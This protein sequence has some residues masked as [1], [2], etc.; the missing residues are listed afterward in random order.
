MLD[1]SA[2]DDHAIAVLGLGVSGL[3]A[4][5][6]L[7]RAG[8]R[9]LPWDDNENRRN[10][11]AARGLTPCNL[12][13]A[14]FGDI[15]M[16][17][18]SPGIP[19]GHPHTHPV[20]ARARDAKCEILCDIELLT[21]AAPDARYIGI[22]GTNGKST[23]TAL[24][25]HI[26]S[27][28]GVASA[29]GGNIGAPA[30]SLDALGT[31]GVYVLELSSYQLDLLPAAVFDVAVLLNITP[32]H[33]DRHGGMDGY[34]AAKRR[35]FDGQSATQSAIVG[36]DDTYAKS[37]FSEVQ[38]RDLAAMTPISTRGVC[39]GGIY[40][41][42]GWII[43]DRADN[44]EQIIEMR[45]LPALPGDHNAQNVATAYGAVTAILKS[46]TTEIRAGIIASIARFPGL[47]HR[48]E[49]LGTKGPVRFVNDSKATNAEAAAHALAAYENIYWIAGG[50]AK[51]GGIAALGPFFDRIRHAFLI[52][53]AAEDFEA[54]LKDR[55]ST[56]RSGDLAT[57]TQQ[58][59]D[60]A[61]GDDNA[62]VLLSPACASFDQFPS[63]EA[64]GDAFRTAV[65]A[66]P[67]FV[68]HATGGAA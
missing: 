17:V 44:A 7:R 28:L 67:G 19:Q 32:D 23:T 49:L 2:Y 13:T 55:V 22:T 62:V 43:D 12:E 66:I 8:A 10:G 25:G 56:T 65:A 33:L 64:R 11:A 51:D 46:I 45:T 68:T 16:L 31:D 38:A 36:I 39:A 41:D 26:L 27:E 40:L 47:A 61:A 9:V 15:D 18:L 54:T 37:I 4:A 34:V 3:S 20:V 5:S 29:I 35:V 59:T 48:Q 21:R 60:M 57:A 53:D 52:G 50:I 63:F 42:A 14:E 24:I 1:L 6:E 30:L 58:A